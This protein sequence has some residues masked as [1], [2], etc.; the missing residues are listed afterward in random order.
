MSRVDDGREVDYQKRLEELRQTREMEREQALVESEEAGEAYVAP[1]DELLEDGLAVP[2][3]VWSALFPHQKEGIQWLYQLHMQN[4]GGIL[5]DDMGLGKTVQIAAYLACLQKM[6]L[7]HSVLL[8]CP[9][10]VLWQWVRE[11]HKWCPELRV[12]LLHSSGASSTSYGTTIKHTFEA[13]GVLLT[14]YENLRANAEHLLG[15]EWDYVILDE[16]H[17][18][19]NPDAEITLVCKQ[20]R[21]VHRII[22][23]GSPIQ[24]RLKELWSL[25]DFVFPGKLGTFPT[26][27]D[28]FVLPIR[29]GGYANA[30][31]M[32][33]LMAYKCALVLRDLIAPYMLRRLKKDVQIATALP[34]KME[35]VIFCPLAPAQARIYRAYLASPEVRSVLARDIRPFRALTILR[36]ICNHPSLMTDHVLNDMAEDDDADVIAQSGKLT[37]LQT[38]LD[39]WFKQR[40][41]VLVFAQHRR[42]LDLLSKL[43][44]TLGYRYC[45]LDGTTSV[46]ERQTLIDAYNDPTSDLFCFL[47]TT[48]AGG[49]GVNLTGAD[50]VIIFD[51][52]W[53]P[54][55]DMQARERAWRMGQTK[56]VTIYRLITSGTIEEKIYHRQL[57][58][59][60]LMNKVLRDPK[61]KR[62]FNHNALRDLFTLSDGTELHVDDA[63]NQ[64]ATTGTE[65]GDLYLHG[66]VAP[67][68]K[69]DDETPPENDVALLQSSLGSVA[70][71]ERR[72]VETDEVDDDDD[73]DAE[74]D[75]AEPKADDGG[76]DNAELLQTLFDGGSIKG[77]FSQD[78]IESDGVHNQEA[79]LIEIESAKVAKSALS[80]LRQSCSAIRQQREDQFEVT[81]TG[82]S[83]SAGKRLFGAPARG[84][85]RSS[86]EHAAIQSSAMLQKIKKRRDAIDGT[87]KVRSAVASVKYQSI[88][89]LTKQLHTF[90]ERQDGVKT[91]VI[92]A[93]FAPAVSPKDKD[94]FRNLLR[95][96]ATCEGRVWR[97]KPEFR[98]S[99]H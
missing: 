19:R 9:A 29:H 14:T 85:K 44:G 57:F 26:F 68:P 92:I 78:R 24:N 75:D 7:V 82:K 49:I 4:A 89:E 42:T 53:N 37:V 67:P 91:D 74:M 62:C 96:M 22:L 95:S 16:G 94:V 10:S 51:P 73:V 90:L 17:R 47:L 69:L 80:T 97:L 30:T 76:K 18:I 54:S 70:R 43:M 40:H 36:Q 28:E 98:T 71:V 20:L 77:V 48:K 99:H 52:D 58:K 86:H 66:H 23:T 72:V 2:A 8:A 64:I 12:V 38:I 83:G 3:R 27:E 45:R 79:D 15:K 93:K 39:V 81:W 61:Q 60:Y 56:Q 35:Q 63:G 59:Q 5:G 87:N 34:S 6:Q 46:K 25:F 50:R 21:T 33:I 1:Q 84:L 41:R 32:Q 13:G 88:D 31:K 65:T 11:L 55:T